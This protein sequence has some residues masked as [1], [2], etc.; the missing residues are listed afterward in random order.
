[1]AINKGTI[2]INKL[3]KQ[4]KQGEVAPVYLVLGEESYFL[5]PIKEAFMGLIA[6]EQASFNIGQYDMKTTSLAQATDD[7]MSIPFFGK[8][9]LVII[10]NP[11]FL[12]GEKTKGKIEHDTASFADYLQN[13]LS[14]TVL[15]IFAPYKKLDERKKIVKQ[16]KKSAVI[17]DNSVMN[18]FAVH[19]YFAN[20]VTEAGL[21]I[22]RAALDLILERTDASLQ[23]M[24]NELPKLKVA[25]GEQKKITEKIVDAVVTQ[26][27]EQN[28]FRLVDIVLAKNVP[29][30]LRVYHDL[31]TQKIEPLSINSIL[32]SQ[33]RLLLQTQILRKHGYAQGNIA[34][35][36]K[37]HPYRVKL[38]MQKANHFSRQ[39]LKEAYLGLAEIEEKLKSS[40]Q[41]PELMFQLFMLE[42]SRRKNVS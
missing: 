12:T 34:A 10:K 37:T 25:V 20:K 1:M 32:I 38:A 17:V 5:N 35:V 22:D 11:I 36:L 3:F 21:T 24:M 13:P 27:L 9:R 33:F 41:D 40:R 4:L 6:S 7:A 2:T 14:S 19:N 28:I 30:A 29:A 42:F 18:E 31:L 15:V 16:L 8:R 26:T 23:L 39:D